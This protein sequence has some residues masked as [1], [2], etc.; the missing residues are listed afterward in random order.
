MN[1]LILLCVKLLF[2]KVWY[3]VLG[4]D[5]CSV[6]PDSWVFEGESAVWW[7]PKGI[8]VTT[9]ISKEIQPSSTWILTPFKQ[10]IGPIGE[11][12]FMYLQQ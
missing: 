6:V 9:A 4:D 12:H 2:V 10:L 7:P 1:I 11:L 8:S 3:V 5:W